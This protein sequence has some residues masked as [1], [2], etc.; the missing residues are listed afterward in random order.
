MPELLSLLSTPIE[1][2]VQY[3]V[4]GLGELQMRR[5]MFR[6]NS[7]ER[8]L[9]EYNRLVRVNE[10]LVQVVN[11]R[12]VASVGGAFRKQYTTPVLTPNTASPASSNIDETAAAKNALMDQ[13]A[14]DLEIDKFNRNTELKS[15][16]IYT[17][18]RKTTGEPLEK[19]PD[20]WWEWWRK[21]NHRSSG[22][23]PLT[24][25]TYNQVD[26]AQTS[27]Q[28]FV[29]TGS[30][31][32]SCLV[33]GTQVQTANGLQAVEAIK[34][35]DMV[36]SQDVE[37]GELA[38]KPV[39]RTTCGRRKPSTASRRNQAISSPPVVIAGGSLAKAG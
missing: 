3:A 12:E 31:Q 14:L 13:Q 2:R 7:K 19:K 23:K 9:V 25:R 11:V 8:Q 4:N 33:A 39:V 10:P 16:N 17:V 20:A 30:A 1:T 37:T 18:L 26:K 6:T 32:A 24:R 36:L 28:G 5:A 22:S 34:V 27:L 35:G 15:G 21:Y 29:Y 38:L